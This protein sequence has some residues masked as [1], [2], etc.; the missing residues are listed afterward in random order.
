MSEGETKLPEWA[1]EVLTFWFAHGWDDW[2][3]GSELF[4]SEIREKFALSWARQIR[5]QVNDF[6]GS[7]REALAAVI[8]FD[9]FPRNMFRGHADQFA[10]DHMALA[11][12]KEAIARG[13][14]DGMSRDRRGFLYMPFQHSEEP[15]DQV[16]SLLLFTALGDAEQL[17]YARLH[18]DVIERFGRFPH[19]N[20]AL[21]RKPTAMEQAAGDVVPW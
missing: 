1:E 9:Q 13:Y 11:I 7:P 20:A 4:D 16:Q 17:R 5:R 18:H 10:T 15:K 21:G 14:D 3:K 2:W 8:L 6:L 19:R 12:A